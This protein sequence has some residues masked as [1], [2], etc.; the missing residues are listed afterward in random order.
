M[1]LSNEINCIVLAVL[2]RKATKENI[3]KLKDLCDEQDSSG[4]LFSKLS[5]REW[6]RVNLILLDLTRAKKEIWER[7]QR[8]LPPEE[9]SEKE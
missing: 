4:R 1:I 3:Q 7:I 5:D 2:T 8:R 9:P 6:I